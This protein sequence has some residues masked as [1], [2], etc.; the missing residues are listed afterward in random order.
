MVSQLSSAAGAVLLQLLSLLYVYPLPFFL[1]R[2]ILFLT[3]YQVAGLF[4]VAASATASVLFGVLVGAIQTGLKPFEIKATMGGRMFAIT[5]LAAAFSLAGGFFWLFSVCCCSGRSPYSHDD[6]KG[7]RGIIAE[8]A[9]YT[10]E[11]VASPYG[12]QTGAPAGSSV[13]L[14]NMPP[15]ESAYEPYRHDQRV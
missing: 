11:R 14:H 1:L 12:P 13:P 3:I 15:Q 5:W 8:K 6:R 2:F 9:P 4:T 7:R 10:Y